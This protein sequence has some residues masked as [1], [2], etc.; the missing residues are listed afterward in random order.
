MWPTRKT[1]FTAN[2]A[3][4][5]EFSAT[6][7][8]LPGVAEARVRET[9]ALQ[10]VASVRRLDYT[11]I[12]TIRDIAPGRADP[13]SPLFDP[14]RAAILH[15]RAGKMEEAFWLI[16]LATHFGKH[17]N[18]GWRRLRD[19]YSGLGD[20]TWTWERYRAD[21]ESFRVW[22]SANWQ[23][24]GGGFGN[25]R[26]YESLDTLSTKGT[27]SVLNSYFNWIGDGSLQAERFT[28][29]IREAGNDP[30][31]IFDHIYKNMNVL[32]FGRLGKFDFLCLL[33]RLRLLPINPGSPYLKGASGPL[34][35]ARLLFTGNSENSTGVALLETWLAE[36]NGEL[37]LDNQV[38]ED[39]LCNWQKS[40][41]AFIHFQG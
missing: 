7:R 11:H 36:L 12:L 1:Q 31:T 32:R 35:G 30:H 6:R 4:L 34:R 21:P 14:E 29:L 38:I 19:V 18:Y 33:G 13:L 40:P 27:A 26:K 20:G 9:L 39:S 2:Y 10:M 24:I 25:H 28:R 8:P 22:L 15:A 5:T 16:F 3:I 37:R 41:A 23:H 17:A